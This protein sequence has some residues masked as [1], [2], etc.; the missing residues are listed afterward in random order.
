MELGDNDR[1]YELYIYLEFMV[2]I[3]IFLM[4]SILIVCTASCR[5]LSNFCRYL[6]WSLTK[7]SMAK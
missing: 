6:H 4:I 2:F 3:N 1:V 5:F 7:I